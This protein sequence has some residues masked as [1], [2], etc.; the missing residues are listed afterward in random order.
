MARA[1]FHDQLESVVA[2][3]QADQHDGDAR[4]LDVEDAAQTR[5]QEGKS[6]L[7]QAEN[8]H[9]AE[10]GAHATDGLGHDQGPEGR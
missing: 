2:Q 10:N 1:R 5:E 9:R 4:D 7:G 3:S 6:D 8:A